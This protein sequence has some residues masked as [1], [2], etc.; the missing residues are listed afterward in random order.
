MCCCISFEKKTSFLSFENKHNSKNDEEE[1]QDEEKIFVDQKRSKEQE[2]YS[3][4]CEGR[5][6]NLDDA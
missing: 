1:E 4:M 2:I 3:K 6:R 5:E